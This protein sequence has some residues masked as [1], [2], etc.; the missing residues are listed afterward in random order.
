MA[1]GDAAEHDTS[2]PDAPDAPDAE[3]DTGYTPVK[4]RRRGGVLGAAMMGL[5]EALYGPRENE[6]V[7]VAD[8]DGMPEPDFKV[9]LTPDPRDSTVRFRRHWWQRH[10]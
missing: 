4:R 2:S 8:A 3:S 10:H 7:V 9:D 5:G 1:E 6:I